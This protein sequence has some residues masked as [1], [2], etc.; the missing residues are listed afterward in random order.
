MITTESLICILAF[1]LNFIYIGGIIKKTQEI[2]V[3][4]Q[5][6]TVQWAVIG[7]G[8]A[9]IA[10]VGKLI[11]SGIEPQTIAWFDPEFKV[12]DFGSKWDKVSSNTKVKLFLKFFEDCPSFQYKIAPKFSIQNL[13]PEETCE[14]SL[15]AEPLQWITEHLKEKV[16]VFHEKV[17]RLKLHSRHWDITSTH[18]KIHAKNVIL[19]IGAEPKSLSF[20]GKEEIP[21]DIALH[22][23]K[24]QSVCKQDDT[25]GVFGSSHSAICILKNL[26]EDCNVNKVIN[27]YLSP[28][29]YAVHF[30]DWILFDNTGLKGKAAKWA[31]E[32][33]D[34]KHPEKLE[35]IIFNE[36]NIHPNFHLCNKMI[37]ATGFKKRH[38][39]IEGMDTVTY[40]EKNGIIAPGLFGLG[41]AFPEA[42]HDRFGTLEYSV[43]LW[44]FMDYL[45]RV[46]PVWL[47]YT[48]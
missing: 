35:R 27:F 18:Q 17:Q 13:D 41:L 14:L 24:L 36:K 10:A 30:E 16:H 25:I 42:K 46:M 44:K 9:G 40:N 15:A 6:K 28:L 21:L 8:P 12:G 1:Q 4:M 22:P 5:N 11:D 19:A 3:N 31:R 33:I 2:P 47:K 23:E 38:I 43:G 39:T 32:H 29:R 45:N 37:Y 20:E 7:A 26:L 48:T 34:G